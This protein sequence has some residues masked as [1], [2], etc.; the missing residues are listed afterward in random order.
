MELEIKI[1]FFRSPSH[2]LP[3]VSQSQFQGTA[4]IPGNYQYYQIT[5]FGSSVSNS[6]L[7]LLP[8]RLIQLR[9]FYPLPSSIIQFG[10]NFILIEALYFSD[11]DFFTHLIPIRFYNH[12]I[13]RSSSKCFLLGYIERFLSGLYGTPCPPSPS[14]SFPWTASQSPTYASGI[15]YKQF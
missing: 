7:H 8:N 13:F 11:E 15:I 4:F 14:S 1:L 12:H 10:Q 2:I 5:I 3:L 6:Y 9:F